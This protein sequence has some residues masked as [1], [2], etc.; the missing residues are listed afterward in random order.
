MSR[1]LKLA[2][3]NKKKKKRVKNKLVARK[4]LLRNKNTIRIG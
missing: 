1:R 2:I 4:D 3:K